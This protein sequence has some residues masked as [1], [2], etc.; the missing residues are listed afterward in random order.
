MNEKK[1]LSKLSLKK[2]TIGV[3]NPQD[4]FEI[5][6]GITTSFGYQNERCT[7]LFCCGSQAMPSI[8]RTCCNETTNCG[9]NP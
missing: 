7:R 5:K 3:L 6:G 4:Q 2:E 8:P 1:K 9:Q